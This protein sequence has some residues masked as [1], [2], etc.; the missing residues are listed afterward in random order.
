METSFLV[1]IGVTGVSPVIAPTKVRG[2][3]LPFSIRRPAQDLCRT[4][5]GRTTILKA[6]PFSPFS[7]FAFS[8]PIFFLENFL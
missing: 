4:L 3:I 6:F 7:L 1:C 2:Y 8:P 5:L